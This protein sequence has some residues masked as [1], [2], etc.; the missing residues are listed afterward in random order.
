M[1]QF[2]TVADHVTSS[3][4]AL[5]QN[6][7]KTHETKQNKKTETENLGLSR[8]DLTDLFDLI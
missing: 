5:K 1:F 8:G 2:I 6:K 7:T 3:S 4:T